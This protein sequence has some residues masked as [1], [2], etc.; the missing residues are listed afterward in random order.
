MRDGRVRRKAGSRKRE[1]NTYLLDGRERRECVSLEFGV[2][3]E[4]VGNAKVQCGLQN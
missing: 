4:V 3:M 1:L 2:R